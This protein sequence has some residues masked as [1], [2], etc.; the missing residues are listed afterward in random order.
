MSKEIRK[1][2]QAKDTNVDVL[3]VGSGTGMMAAL[4][5]KSGGLS[6]LIIEKTEVV[7]GSVARSGGAFWIPANSV[8]LEEGQKDTLEEGKTYLSTLAQDSPEKRWN[9]FLEYGDP[10]VNFLRENTDLDFMW[11]KGY[12]DYHPENPGGKPMGR[13]VE[14]KPFNVASLGEEFNRFRPGV[15]EASVP[16]PITGYA[17]KRLNLMMRMPFQAL[18]IILKNLSKGVGGKILGKNYQAGGQALAAGLFK[19]V[20]DADIPVWTRTEMKELMYENDRIVGVKAVQDG[21][22]VTIRANKGVILATGGFDHDQEMRIKHNSDRFSKREYSL[23]AEGNTGDGIKIAE[24]IGAD[25]ALMDQAW[26]FPAIAP[27][28]KGGQVQVMLAERS[29][30]G[31]FIINQDGERFINEAT[32]YMTFGQKIFELEKEGRPIDDMY[33]ILD[34]KYKNSYLFGGSVFPYAPFPEEWYEAGIVHKAESPA[35]LAKAIGVPAEK[36]EATFQKF[37]QMAEKGKDTEFQR[38]DSAYD[39]Y[40][41]DPTI[42]PNPNL[43]P[44]DSSK[45]LYAVKM[46]LSDLGTC[47]G[48]K[49][50]ELGRALRPDGSVIDG[51]YAIGN[52]AANVFGKSYPGAGATIG[53]GIVFGYIA[54][55]HIAES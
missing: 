33:I 11:S 43:R 6:T 2:P 50:D 31:S 20:I 14:Y 35:A 22:E 19:A 28:K 8:L 21:Q 5:A 15:M 24:K 3:V 47:G 7:G 39:R 17:Y 9:A 40:Y 49:A 55:K 10:A 16:M 44:L 23:G 18:P 12:S 13:S 42:K 34:T 48:I 29:L 26:W 54:A 38:G 41:G 45:T 53:Q 51:L 37:N 46:V 32:D 4:K 52:N 1:G 25:K 27:F 36:F 30:P